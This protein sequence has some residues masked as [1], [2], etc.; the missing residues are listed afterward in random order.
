MLLKHHEQIEATQN[1]YSQ[2]SSHVKEQHSLL[3]KLDETRILLGMALKDMQALIADFEK[4]FRAVIAPVNIWK[5]QAE[6]N[7]PK[8]D[9]RALGTVVE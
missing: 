4:M 8:R 3:Q 5:K 2:A 9:M 7:Y 1:V 6:H